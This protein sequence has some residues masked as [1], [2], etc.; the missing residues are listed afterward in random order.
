MTTKRSA[1]LIVNMTNEFLYKEYGKEVVLERAQKM[2]P[3]I[4]T[5][6]DEFIS[7]NLPVIYLNDS[8]LP[9]DYEIR[10]STAKGIT[11]L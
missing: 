6:R 3:A 4:R 9:T 10:A 1:L 8:H 7:L 5:L 2:I 11:Y